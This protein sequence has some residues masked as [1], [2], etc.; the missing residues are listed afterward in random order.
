MEIIKGLESLKKPYPDTVLTIGNFDG[1]HIGHQ[2]ILSGVVHEADRLRGTPMVVTFNPHPMKV[3]APEKELRILT[4]FGEKAKLI[5][6]NGIKAMLCITFTKQFAGLLPDEFIEDVLVKKLGA[7]EIIVGSHYAFGKNK[8][9][10]ISLLRRRG[11]KYGFSVRVIRNTRLHGDVVSS[12]RIRNLLSK[13]DVREISC[14]LGRAYSISGKVIRGK[15][16]GASI[17]NIPTAN[18][19][20]PVEISPREGV[21]AV[22]IA[23][24]KRVLDGVANIGK[25]PTFGNDAISYEVHV[26]NYAGNLLDREIRI[27]FV[28]ML[29][30]ER[31][32]PDIRSLVKQIHEDIATAK[33]ILSRHHPALL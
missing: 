11:K 4:S 10:N 24:G 25:N 5:A 21:Y 16:R 17:L 18:I 26:F 33:K 32:F 8:K 12:S 23:L 30:G 28:D 1:V 6:E 14:L 31:R 13:G 3:L 7:K 29:R 15:G 27:F 22:R 2:K 19:S 9:G 20:P